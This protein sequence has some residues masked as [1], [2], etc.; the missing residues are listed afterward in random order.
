MDTPNTQLSLLRPG[1]YRIDVSTDRQET[2]LVVREGE[3]SAAVSGG[4]QQVLPGQTAT[5]FGDQD[6]QAD[7]RNGTGLD[8]FDTWSADRDRY[9]RTSRT[10]SYVSPQMVG[11]ADLDAYGAWQTYPD[12]GAVWFPTAVA[13]G[14]APYRDGRW[15]TL[16]GWGLTW[17]DDAPWGYAPFHYGRWVY[18]G[19][20]WGWCPGRY[21]A[22]PVWAP[23]LVA[24]YGGG[25]VAVGGYG[26]VY[27]WVPLGWRDPYVPSWR[28]CSNRCYERYNRPYAVNVAE[29]PRQPPTY[30]ANYRV[31]GAI[32]AV[33]GAAFVAGKPVAPN[34]IGVSNAQFA[35]LPPLASAPRVKPL[36]VTT[37]SVRPGQGAPIP[38]ST[39]L[40][41]TKPMIV[42]PE[43]G[44][45]SSPGL[46]AQ[47]WAKPARGNNAAEPARP[48][49]TPSRGG[50]A[51]NY[52]ETPARSGPTSAPGAPMP[53][54]RPPAT[55]GASTPGA[56]PRRAPANAAPPSR[57]PAN[58]APPPRAPAN[59]VPPSRAP[60]PPAYAPP[61]GAPPARTASPPA[62]VNRAESQA[63]PHP[64][65][66][67][68][69]PPP[70]APAPA[71]LPLHRR[72]RCARGP[73]SPRLRRRRRRAPWL[74]R[75]RRR[76]HL[77]PRRRTRRTSRW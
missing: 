28:N 69:A 21:V 38:A 9:Y 34:R 27:G 26:P 63:Q 16:S 33:P 59:A 14:W 61:S 47:P 25:G 13:A 35:S 51:Q 30:Y 42:A 58:A 55:A 57:A 75:L 39:A 72:C 15:I 49:A 40:G 76:R 23:A 12:Y 37:R 22:R 62:G 31:P 11:A 7:V 68:A 6:V 19:N 5:L 66:P 44:T 10:A 45:A 8:G 73:R 74:R 24:W 53:V 70:R 2:T 54:A 67:R 36:P 52:A 65:A 60:S 64:Y 1:L 71:H 17:V 46:P 4:T 18:V 41:T 20:R 43:R 29:R 48:A 32:T 3:V 56:P 77:H 50:P